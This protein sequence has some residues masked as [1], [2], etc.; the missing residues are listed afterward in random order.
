MHALLLDLVLDLF[1]LLLDCFQLLLSAHVG[2][3]VF[4]F[5]AA[6]LYLRLQFFTLIVIVFDFLDEFP[7]LVR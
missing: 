6:R 3:V 1:E 2:Y 7:Q 5:V 4:V